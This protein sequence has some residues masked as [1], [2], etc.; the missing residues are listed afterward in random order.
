MKSKK[1][2]L[3]ELKMHNDTKTTSDQ[4]QKLT[5]GIF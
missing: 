1:L 3:A 4:S 5:K 2:I